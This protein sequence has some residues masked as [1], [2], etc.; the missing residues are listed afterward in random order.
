M[1]LWPFFQIHRVSR[2]CAG[3]LWGVKPAFLLALSV[4]CA[5][6]SAQPP[7]D[8]DMEARRQAL[9][10]MV[11]PQVNIR[12]SEHATGAEIVEITM[13]DP[14]YPVSMVDGF[15]KKLGEL[16]GSPPRGL[17][18]GLV[19]IDE[20]KKLGFVRASFATDN[21][22][23]HV[24]Q[25]LDLNTVIKAFLGAP[26]PNTI[27]TLQ[28]VFEGEK[29]GARTLKSFT[30]PNLNYAVMGEVYQNPD[31]IEYRVNLATQDPQLINVPMNAD[32]AV[33]K[34]ANPM[35]GPRITMPVAILIAAAGI[36]LGA[37]VY[38]AMLR[39]PSES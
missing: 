17:K 39:R 35:S 26:E 21:L 34:K 37:L 15:A 33:K 20:E 31:S 29:P 4:M 28:V 27:K 25:K 2:V 1:T 18:A 14:E 23:D 8:S 5:L 10:T 22:I 36:A 30:D 12:I 16:A 19:V 24:T 11:S 9:E 3:K 6:L 7:G 32:E 38:F 13:L